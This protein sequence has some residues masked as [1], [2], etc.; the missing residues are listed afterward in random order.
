M[1][2]KELIEKLQQFEY[3]DQEI[4]VSINN[5]DGIDISSLDEGVFASFINIHI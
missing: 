4:F 5:S 2:V 3:Q 1:T